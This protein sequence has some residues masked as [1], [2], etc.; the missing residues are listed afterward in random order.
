MLGAGLGLKLAHMRNNKPSQECT[1]CGLRYTIDNK[2][3]PHCHNLSD[4]QLLEL[5]E[6]ISNEHEA[7]K[8]LGKV[9]FI[10]AIAVIA[11][12]ILFYL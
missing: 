7:N 5:K 1:R 12:M 8:G 11:L 2:N 9:F 10:I 4:S 3:C 6:K